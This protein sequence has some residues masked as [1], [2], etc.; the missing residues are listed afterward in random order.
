M[1]TGDA[2]GQAAPPGPWVMQAACTTADPEVFFPSRR[3][4]SAGEEAKAICDGCPVRAEC[5]EYALATHQEWGVW[6]GTNEHERRAILRDR[7]RQPEA[8]SPAGAA[9]AA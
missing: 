3:N 6:G 9:G 8:P 2:H 4:A 5:L 7:D 1:E